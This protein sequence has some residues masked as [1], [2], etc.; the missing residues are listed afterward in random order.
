MD[1]SGSSD[2]IGTAIPSPASTDTATDTSTEILGTSL[3]HKRAAVGGNDKM[4][5]SKKRKKS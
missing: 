5:S 2:T 1:A 3:A 4:V